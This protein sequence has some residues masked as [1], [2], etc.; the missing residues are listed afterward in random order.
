MHGL[1]ALTAL[2]RVSHDP[3]VLARMLELLDILCS[4]LQRVQ[5]L[6]FEGYEPG[7]TLDQLWRPTPGQV[8]NYGE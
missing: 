3:V 5:G 8:V 6:I 2:H 7:R 1:E 4:R